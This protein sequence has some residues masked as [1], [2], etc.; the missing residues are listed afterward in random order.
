M[1]P[2]NGQIA[3]PRFDTRNKRERDA[4]AAWTMARLHQ[5]DEDAQE[6]R[7]YDLLGTPE[8]G[9]RTEYAVAKSSA[10]SGNLEALRAF[11]VSITGDPEIA[12][13]IAEPRRPRGR[14]RPQKTVKPFILRA[15]KY[16]A[17]VTVKRVQQIWKRQYRFFLTRRID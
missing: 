4:L 9:A 15:S 7:R 5:F 14:R 11:F 6:G 8:W 10:R 17:V 16:S 1:K 2:T 12:E 13:F 3:A